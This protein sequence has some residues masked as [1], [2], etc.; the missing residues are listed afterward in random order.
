MP[1]NYPIGRSGSI[2]FHVIDPVRLRGDD[3]AVR[4]DRTQPKENA[5]TDARTIAESYIAVWN[6][7]EASRRAALLETNWARQARYIDPVM[8]GDGR[9]E[10][11]QLIG[12]VH[13]RFPGFRFS[14]IGEPD[15]FDGHVR[16]SWG[17]GP[18]G[19]DAIVKGSDVAVLEDGRIASVIGFLDEVPADA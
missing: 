3:P 14:L 2:T 18:A 10:I 13:Q 12:A 7:T 8:R 16:F 9:E 17:L 11:G 15:G 5:M 6:E 4:F 19:E 1:R